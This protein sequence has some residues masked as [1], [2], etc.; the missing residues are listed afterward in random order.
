MSG[1]L[2]PGAPDRCPLCDKKNWTG[3]VCYEC[4]EKEESKRPPRCWDCDAGPN[5]KHGQNCEATTEEER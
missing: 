3:R 1:L 4:E 2:D 5:E